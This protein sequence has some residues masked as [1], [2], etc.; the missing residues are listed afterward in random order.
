MHVDERVDC[1]L[2]SVGWR[3]H[4]EALTFLTKSLVWRCQAYFPSWQLPYLLY[5]LVRHLCRKRCWWLYCWFQVGQI[6]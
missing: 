3:M 6:L 4:C 5:L 1:W 2:L